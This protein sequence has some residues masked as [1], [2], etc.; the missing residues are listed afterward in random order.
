MPSYLIAEGHNVALLDLDA[1][2]PQ[3]RSE[4]LK[5]ARRTYSPDGSVHE[6]GLYIE[7]EWGLLGSA[8][9]Y[10]ALLTQFG[11]DAAATAAVTIYCPGPDYS[12][13]RYNGTAVRPEVGR[14]V[15]RRGYF[16]RDV[17]ILV[18]GLEEIEE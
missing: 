11:L 3:P 6:E 5:A 16:I 1:I 2:S 14:D 13:A 7:L 10:Q 15:R 17:I 12:Y 4:G 18:R 9:A 8:T